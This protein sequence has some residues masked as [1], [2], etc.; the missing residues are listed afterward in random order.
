M[1]VDFCDVHDEDCGNLIGHFRHL[2]SRP[3]A[4]TEDDFW[5]WTG[6]VLNITGS[7]R[8]MQ[9]QSHHTQI[10]R[11]SLCF[12]HFNCVFLPQN[13]YSTTTAHRE[14]YCYNIHSTP[15]PQMQ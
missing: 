4:F 3:S 13:I 6:L 11:N 15:Q 14:I 1:C 10:K 9:D 5:E 8:E 7:G 2:L 12:R